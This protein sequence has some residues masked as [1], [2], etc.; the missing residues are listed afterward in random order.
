M[1]TEPTRAATNAP[2]R[3][4]VAPAARSAAALP[5]S[6]GA[7]AAG[8]VRRRAAMTHMRRPLTAPA[9]SRSA[10]ELGEVRVTLLLEGLAALAS[11]LAS[12]EEQ[13]RVVRQLLNPR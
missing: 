4:P 10:R 11:L 12:V 6:T 7:I 8:S 9:T 13:V 5:T 2:Q 1:K 3:K